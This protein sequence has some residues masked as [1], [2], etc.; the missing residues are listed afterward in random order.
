MEEK[1]QRVGEHNMFKEIPLPNFDNRSEENPKR[2]LEEFE[3]FIKLREVHS[4]WRIYWFKKCLGEATR[5]WFDAVGRDIM[6]FEE[7]KRRFLERYWGAERQSEIIR[8]FY[9]PGTYNNKDRTR[10]QYLLAAC[11]KNRYLYIPLSERSLV[12]AISR[13]LGAEIAKHT[14]ASNIVTIEDFARMLNV[15]EEVDKEQV[16]GRYRNGPELYNHHTRGDY[17]KNWRKSGKKDGLR[18]KAKRA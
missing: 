4:N 17:Y 10:E 11:R 3:E 14:A 12:G 16:S 15:W 13:Q 6:N 8:K 7:L 18:R 5:L 9:T 1:T 2:F